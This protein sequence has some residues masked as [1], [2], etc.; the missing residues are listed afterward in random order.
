MSLVDLVPR[1]AGSP[2]HSTGTPL[3]LERG[4]HFVDALG[5][6][7]RP[8]IGVEFVRSAGNGTLRVVGGGTVL[9]RG[10]GIGRRGGCACGA[11]CVACRL[12]AARRFA[13]FLRAR[14]RGGALVAQRHA[15]V[16]AEHDDDGVRLF[17]RRARL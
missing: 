16:Q 7:R 10:F 1:I 5:V 6:K 9:R 13:F 15:V 2:T 8:L 4:D 11:V 3:A 14:R 17:G 12:P